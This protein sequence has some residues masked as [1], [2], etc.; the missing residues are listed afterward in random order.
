MYSS[1]RSRRESYLPGFSAR[2]FSVS[3]GGDHTQGKRKSA[4]PI[5]PKQALHV[6][7]KAS[8]ARGALSMLHPKHCGPI[9]QFTHGLAQRWGIRLYRYANVGNHIHLLIKVPSSAVWQRFLRELAGGIPLI[10]T[11]A[12]KGAPFAKS[13]K[14]RGFWDALAFTR[15]VRL[16]RDFEGMGRYLIKNLFEGAGIPVNQLLAQGARILSVGKVGFSSC[17]P[18]VIAIH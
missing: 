15:I 11:G 17:G 1:M 12:K 2:T 3:H 13:G 9:H 7:L 16:G 8:V 18:P 14:Q 5:D 4:R 10:V 6:V